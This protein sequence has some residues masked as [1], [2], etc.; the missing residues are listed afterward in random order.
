[1]STDHSHQNGYVSTECVRI[2]FNMPV[3]CE[4]MY[5]CLCVLNVLRLC[6][7]MRACVCVC[8]CVCVLVCVCMCVCVRV[9]SGMAGMQGQIDP[10]VASQHMKLV[11][12]RQ[13][14]HTHTHT[15]IHTHT[16]TY[17]HS[18]ISLPAPHS[19]TLIMCLLLCDCVDNKHISW[20]KLGVT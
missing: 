7:C 16:H 11:N 9:N 5:R 20:C 8:V 3:M 10:S 12:A 2:C 1:M 15:H 18:H 17:I 6:V 13:I 4:R 19:H 14:H